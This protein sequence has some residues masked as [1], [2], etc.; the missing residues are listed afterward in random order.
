MQKLTYTHRHIHKPSPLFPSFPLAPSSRTVE[1]EVEFTT[2]K[3]GLKFCS[4]NSKII[5]VG[6]DGP[7]LEL[8]G[9][10]NNS[11]SSMWGY[12]PPKLKGAVLVGV[13]HVVVEELAFT[14]VTSLLSQ[15]CRHG[16]GCWVHEKKLSKFLILFYYYHHDCYFFERTG[17]ICLYDHG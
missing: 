3:L 16:W 2:K 10:S 1:Y 7:E 6:Y 5:V 4:Q 17:Y 8:L 11:S 9:G 12:N 15:V 13:N 14:K